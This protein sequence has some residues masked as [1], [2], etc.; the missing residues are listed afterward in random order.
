[1]PFIPS[2]SFKPSLQSYHDM[3]LFFLH[4]CLLPIFRITFMDVRKMSSPRNTLHKHITTAAA[5]HDISL[6]RITSLFNYM[7]HPTNRAFTISPVTPKSRFLINIIR[8]LYNQ[9]KVFPSLAKMVY[10]IP[11][12]QAP[13][14]LAH[15]VR[16]F[17]WLSHW[18][19]PTYPPFLRDDLKVTHATTISTS[20][21]NIGTHRMLS[22]F[23]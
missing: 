19:F 6:F 3:G 8:S 23:V 7:S 9:I 16:D 12:T 15:A 11:N 14:I 2:L 18:I 10:L 5:K 22:Q 1:M 4:P 13:Y 20:P 21:F 17:L